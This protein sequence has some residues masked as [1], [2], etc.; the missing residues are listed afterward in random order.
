MIF[1]ICLSAVSLMAQSPEPAKA[2]AE[3]S[4]KTTRTIDFT[5]DEGTW[6]SMDVSPDGKTVLLDLLGHLYTLMIEGGTAHAITH[7]LSFNTQPRYSPDGKWL[8]FVS[9]R[10]GA[11]NIWMCRC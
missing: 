6:M 4:L 3:L 7:G 11:N 8:V 10:G 2:L 9:D 5:V 1:L